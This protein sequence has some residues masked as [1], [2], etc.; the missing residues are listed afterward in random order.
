MKTLMER[1][2]APTPKFFK[3]L[4]NIGLVISAVGT[5]ILSAPVTLPATL[6][7]ISGYLVTAGGV[8]TA[9]S[10]LTIL[11]DDTPEPKPTSDES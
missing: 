7:A 9:V 5:A 8:V 11:H 6:I 1:W 2:V 3:V 4:R 10:Q